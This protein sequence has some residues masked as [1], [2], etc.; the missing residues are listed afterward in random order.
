M[1][2]PRAEERAAHAEARDDRVQ[3]LAPVDLLVEERV[4]EVEASDPE[5]DGSAEHPGLPRQPPGDRHP[6]ADGRESVDRAEPE[7]AEP[8]EALEV[9]I[10]D[11][12]DH[13][14]RPEPAHEWVELP[15]R[16]EEER[17]RSGAEDDDLGDRELAARELAA[18]RPRVSRVDARIDQAVERHRQRAGADHGKRDPEEIVSARRPVDCEERADVGKRQR[19]DRV[20]DLDEP[21]EARREAAPG[22]VWQSRLLVGRRSVR[23]QLERVRKR[24]RRTAKPSRQPPVEPGRLTTSV[25]PRT[26]AAPRERRPCGVL[27]IESARSACAMPGASRSSTSRVAS[28]VTSRGASPVPPVVRT[29]RADAASS[30]IA[31][32][33]WPRSSGTTRRSTS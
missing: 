3:T 8:R 31:A 9:R 4:E 16:G 7:M 29:S 32:A 2:E 17:E 10:D 25:E 33:I 24:G 26:P 22:L 13:R 19:E 15:D 6:C 11:E 5:R 18:G 30:R 21:R 20:L 27:A 28:G 1:R 14:D 23:E 12:A